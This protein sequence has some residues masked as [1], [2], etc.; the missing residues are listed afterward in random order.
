MHNQNK[1]IGEILKRR[2]IQVLFIISLLYLLIG[3]STSVKVLIL[4]LLA[5]FI[6]PVMVIS[7]IKHIKSQNGE[8]SYWKIGTAEEFTKTESKTPQESEAKSTI[9]AF[10]AESSEEKSNYGKKKETGKHIIIAIAIVLMACLLFGGVSEAGSLTFIV[11]AI[12]YFV[13]RK[14]K[15]KKIEAESAKN[16]GKQALEPAEA[17]HPKD[18]LQPTHP[19]ALK[20]EET[21]SAAPVFSV[22]SSEK[23]KISDGVKKSFFESGSVRSETTYKNGKKEGKEKHYFENGKVRLSSPYK[24][25]LIDGI[26]KE[27]NEKGILIRET[28]YN[29]GEKQ[30]AEKLCYPNG[31]VSS[32]VRYGKSEKREGE[33]RFYDEYSKVLAEIKY[34]ADKPVSGFKADKTSG[35]KKALSAQELEK[36]S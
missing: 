24:N 36:Y 25:G 27:Y 20:V 34:S 18:S 12:L 33:A 10:S 5:A 3:K 26:E 13:L 14:G 15:A 17:E 21:Q 11:I 30:G 23:E 9:P 6:I 29:D 8:V 28:R 22:E 35:K 1:P 19:A 32:S 4:V 7:V 16:S 31:R 2:V